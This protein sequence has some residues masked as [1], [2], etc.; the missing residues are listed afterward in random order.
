MKLVSEWL[1]RPKTISAR[2]H[3]RN[4]SEGYAGYQQHLLNHPLVD[5]KMKWTLIKIMYEDFV[6]PTVR[7]A[8]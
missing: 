7:R 3:Y 1:T 4:H 5:D 8:A 6:E 2:Q